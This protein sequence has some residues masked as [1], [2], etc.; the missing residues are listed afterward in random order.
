[1]KNAQVEEKRVI[2]D[3]NCTF[4]MIKSEEGFAR[5]NSKNSENG[6]KSDPPRKIMEGHH[7]SLNFR[8]EQIARLFA[9]ELRRALLQ[10][11]LR[12]LVLIFRRSANSE[13]RRFQEKSFAQRHV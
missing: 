7:I 2:F 1:M 3:E 6:Q 10:K 12:S 9:F 8:N 4:R 13:Q 5:P 11:C